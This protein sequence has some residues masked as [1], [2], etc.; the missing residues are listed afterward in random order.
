MMIG[1]PLVDAPTLTTS[2]AGP[3]AVYVHEQ[4]IKEQRRMQEALAVGMHQAAFDELYDVA[5][6]ASFKGWDGDEG[7]PVLEE[8]LLHAKAFLESLP[9][10]TRAP[11][12]SVHPDGYL[13]F[14]WYR[15]QSR[16]LSIAVGPQGDLHY[17]ALIGPY[18]QHG[19]TFLVG[20]GRKTI[21]DLIEQVERG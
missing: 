9:W 6:E 1:L 13:S 20:E 3:E 17:A 12:I 7:L 16:M 21:L 10:L 15:S 14:E 8:T 19:T 2:G 18:T 4:Y 11:S 5:S